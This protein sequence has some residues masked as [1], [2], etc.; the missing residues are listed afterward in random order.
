MSISELLVVLIIALVVTK[1]QDLPAIIKSFKQAKTYLASLKEQIFKQ[2]Q[3]HLPDLDDISN[4]TKEQESIKSRQIDYKD[5][6]QELN[7]YLEKIILLQGSYE[8]DYSK[9]ALK[10]EYTK[11]IK[12]QMAKE[13]EALLNKS[14][15]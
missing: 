4:D 1:P 2:L 6:P 14:V 9:E 5:S 13:Q 3:E 11:L 7:F 10:A 12:M 15:K 8:G